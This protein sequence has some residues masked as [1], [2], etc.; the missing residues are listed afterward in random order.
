MNSC[1]LFT[2]CKI[3]QNIT[4]NRSKLS[5]DP[6]KNSQPLLHFCHTPYK[7]EQLLIRIKNYKKID[8]FF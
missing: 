5:F 4:E 1:E 8:H 2:N 7:P 6:T 3:K